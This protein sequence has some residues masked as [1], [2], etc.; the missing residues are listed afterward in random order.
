ML[1]WNNVLNALQLR[2]L[3][4]LSEGIGNLVERAGAIPSTDTGIESFG[5]SF[6]NTFRSAT[7]GL[8]DF[9]H[10]VDRVRGQIS[11]LAYSLDVSAD[12]LLATNVAVARSNRSL[13]D[14]GISQR[15][16]AGLVHAGIVDGNQFGQT[17]VG[18]ADGYGLGAER[19]GAL[20]NQMIALGESAGD[21]A[22]VMG[23]I[24]SVMTAIGSMASEFPDVAADMDHFSTSIVRLGVA[25]Q[26]RGLGPLNDTVAQSV[27]VFQQLASSRRN[28]NQLFTG[29]GSEFDNLAQEL[30]I[31]S[32]DIEGAM[33][34]VRTDPLRFAASMQTLYST[35][36]EGSPRQRRL[37]DQLGQMGDGFRFLV[38]RGGE[39]A[40][41]LQEAAR[42]APNAE[43]ALERV[44]IAAARTSR[45]FSESMSRLQEQFQSRLNRMTTQRDS[46][47]LRRQRDAYQRLGGTIRELAG[48]RGPIGFLTQAWLDHRRHGV[49][50]VVGT[51][52]RRLMPALTNLHPALGRFGQRIQAQLPLLGE[53][54]SGL[55]EFASNA[56]PMATAVGAMGLR[57]G[58]LGRA[59]RFVGP[60]AALAGVGYLIY[61]NWD[62]LPELWDRVR[63]GL[64]TVRDWSARVAETVG[65]FDWQAIGRRL[66]IQ[67]TE[68]ISVAFGMVSGADVSEEGQAL[69]DTIRNIFGAAWQ[70]VRGVVTGFSARIV[71]W[72]F[73]PDRWQDQAARGA[74]L[75][76]A[77]LGAGMLTP[78][79]GSILRGLGLLTR[80]L[81]FSGVAVRRLPVIGPLIGILMDAPT[82]IERFQSGDIVGAVERVWRGVI[83]GLTLGI[84]RILEE[85]FG[86][87]FI[88]DIFGFIFDASNIPNVIRAFQSGDIARGIFESLFTVLNLGMGGIPGIIRAGLSRAWDAVTSWFDSV[89]GTGVATELMAPLREGWDA[90]VEGIQATWEPIAEAAGE[91][92]GAVSD[93]V[94]DL[95]ES[96]VRPIFQML[97]RLWDH[98]FRSVIV[99]VARWA[100]GEV[101]RVFDRLKTAFTGTLETMARAASTVF[102][103]IHDHGVRAVTNLATFWIRGFFSIVE[104]VVTLQARWEGLR[105]TMVTGARLV[106]LNL[107]N[108][109]LLPLLEARNS[110]LSFSD[111]LN[112]GFLR[113]RQQFTD[114]GMTLLGFLQRIPAALMPEGM[115]RGLEDRI[116]SLRADH[117]RLAEQIRTTEQQTTNE[118]RRRAEQR[119][120]ALSEAEAAER[121]FAQAREDAA[122]SVEREAAGVRQGRDRALAGVRATGEVLRDVSGQLSEITRQLSTEGGR[123]ELMDR[124]RE[125]LLAIEVSR[126]AAVESGI[127]DLLRSEG[128]AE[129]I[130][131]QIAEGILAGV[132][133]GAAMSGDQVREIVREA[134]AGRAEAAAELAGIRLRPVLEAEAPPTVPVTERSGRRAAGRTATEERMEASERRRDR[135][136]QRRM[137]VVIAAFS[138]EAEASLGRALTVRIPATRGGRGASLP[139]GAE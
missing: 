73:E 110:M 127:E 50:G 100:H 131:E 139:G 136:E 35:M 120:E 66:G 134:R 123:R 128:I 77:A 85:S 97:G 129:P 4:E 8:G 87:S 62:R 92:F 88:S 44:G 51:I 30:G 1:G 138:R 118:Q 39:A 38:T 36:E 46:A 7:A 130:R 114:L 19:A 137:E 109:L 117:A 2:R 67:L 28:L 45:T 76:G 132:E 71:E 78:L 9:R 96:D 64:F 56:A 105:N 37:I 5:A 15:A 108:F 70:V 42:A 112:L 65:R 52:E 23:Q 111:A 135:Q 102:S 74:G 83:D 125:R 47:I 90:F 43:G 116:T 10:H 93:I 81:R 14:F 84:P 61:R 32:G 103:F 53:F 115:A 63:E 119:A 122:A 133:S 3:N 106:G 89:G 13:Q 54:S 121:A 11:G 59:L 72:I 40:A 31:A 99:P 26:R 98:V 48:R 41:A 6:S 24:P 82:I 68:A 91:A 25:M 21:V 60:L 126:R 94:S 33:E 22:G 86:M 113:I 124:R 75:A 80:S 16:L 104:S 55:L 58:H 107:R 101:A 17:L 69:G 49:L 18:W 27:T 95:W 29:L 12:S 34:I 20:A 79:R 57:F